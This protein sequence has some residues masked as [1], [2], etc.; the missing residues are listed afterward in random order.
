MN[1]SPEEKLHFHFYQANPTH[2][3]RRTMASFIRELL[4]KPGANSLVQIVKFT[5]P[6]D[7]LPNSE[8]VALLKPLVPPSEYPNFFLLHLPSSIA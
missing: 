5:S 3:S 2:G 7:E 6:G 4:T 1:F 8:L